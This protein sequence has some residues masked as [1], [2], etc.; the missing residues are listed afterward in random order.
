MFIK[1]REMCVGGREGNVVFFFIFL[2][3]EFKRDSCG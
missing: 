3:F 2:W 1:I